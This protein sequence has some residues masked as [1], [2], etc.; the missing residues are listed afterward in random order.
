MYYFNI[1]LSAALT[2]ETF[3]FPARPMMPTMKKTIAKV[4]IKNVSGDVYL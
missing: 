1:R 4:S 3:F 2:P